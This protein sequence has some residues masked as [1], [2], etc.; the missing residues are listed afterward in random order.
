[1]NT[2]K[3]LREEIRTILHLIMD[4]ELD[5]FINEVKDESIL[6]EKLKRLKEEIDEED[7][8]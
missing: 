6:H 1:M 3:Q 2:R 4:E 5:K 8:S 7:K